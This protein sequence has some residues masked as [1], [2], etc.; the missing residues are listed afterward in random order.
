M[1]RI[2]ETVLRGNDASK[3]RFSYN[4]NELPRVSSVLSVEDGSGRS[5]NFEFKSEGGN[6]FSVS[7]SE[8]EKFAGFSVGNMVTLSQKN[9]QYKIRVR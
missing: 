9:N 8:W 4:G 6:M 1:G 2:F 3:Y 5:W 7:G